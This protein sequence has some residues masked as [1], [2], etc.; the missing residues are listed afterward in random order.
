VPSDLRL[1]GSDLGLSLCT[2]FQLCH[3]LALY[4]WR[5]NLLAKYDIADF[6]GCQGCDVHAI[7]FTE[8]LMLRQC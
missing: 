1:H 4:G 2:L 3:L 5:G 7:T 8:V 6:A